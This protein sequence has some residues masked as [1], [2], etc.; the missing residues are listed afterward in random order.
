MIHAVVGAGVG[1]AIAVG[2]K[3]LAEFDPAGIGV[4]GVA[5][6]V[7]LV[8]DNAGVSIRREIDPAGVA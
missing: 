7:G 6:E 1:I 8:D 5:G 4:E 2:G 3:A